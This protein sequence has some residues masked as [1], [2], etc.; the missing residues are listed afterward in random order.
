MESKKSMLNYK[1]KIIDTKDPK[2]LKI[3]KRKKLK[4]YGVI[5]LLSEI[6]SIR[7]EKLNKLKIKEVV[8]WFTF[9]GLTEYEVDKR[10]VSIIR[11]LS[12]NT[13]LDLKEW[14]EAESLL[15]EEGILTKGGYM[16]AI[17]RERW[18]SR[19]E[20]RQEG[21][22]EGLEKGLQ[23]GRQ[24]VILNMLKEKLDLSVISKV[25]GLSEEEINK[26]KNG[27]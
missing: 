24:A 5:K 2:V 14:K 16:D 15:V 10:V 8:S 1:P 19:Q 12:K 7:K 23:T 17:E 3:Y 22:Q 6:W 4:G 20:G 25:T 21:I 13:K 18:E 27:N 9:K 26:L 11:Y